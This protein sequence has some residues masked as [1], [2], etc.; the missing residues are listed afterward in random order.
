MRYALSTKSKLECFFCVP[1][2]INSVC[3][4]VPELVIYLSRQPGW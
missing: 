1:F 2:F 4:E 3:C